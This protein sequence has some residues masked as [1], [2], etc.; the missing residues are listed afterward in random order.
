M[1]SKHTFYSPNYIKSI[2]EGLGLEP[3]LVSKVL[4]KE[5][6][7]GAGAGASPSS[8]MATLATEEKKKLYETNIINRRKYQPY[9]DE[10][11]VHIGTFQ[12]ALFTDLV[13]GPHGRGRGPPKNNKIWDSWTGV[14]IPLNSVE[15]D[16]ESALTAIQDMKEV[17]TAIEEKVCG[18]WDT[19]NEQTKKKVMNSWYPKKFIE[20]D[21]DNNIKETT[22]YGFPTYYDPSDGMV[23]LEFRK[24]TISNQNIM[25]TENLPAHL[26][27]NW[28][29]A[30]VNIDDDEEEEEYS[31]DEPHP[32][33]HKNYS[34]FMGTPTKRMRPSN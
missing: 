4:N 34:S 3:E 14:W 17:I 21:E 27:L 31:I 16:K 29:E 7:T 1:S 10:L 25:L 22:L 23:T 13:G 20:L 19:M 12:K 2:A 33:P 5:A 24:N 9:L 30:V 11:E 28:K 6:A 18:G 32:G 26:L 8:H 15:E